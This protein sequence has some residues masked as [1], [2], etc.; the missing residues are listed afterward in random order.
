MDLETKGGIQGVDEGWRWLYS[1]R[2]DDDDDDE[3][4]EDDGDDGDDEDDEDDEEEDVWDEEEDGD[5]D[6][7]EEDE[8]SHWSWRPFHFHSLRTKT[9]I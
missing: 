5:G 1:S 8:G 7:Y 6:N 4:D 2:V 3:D 9:K